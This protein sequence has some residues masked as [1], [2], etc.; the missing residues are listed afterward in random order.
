MNK[1]YSV[2]A[3]CAL[4][5]SCAT[6]PD[7]KIELKL[8]QGAGE[9]QSEEQSQIAQIALGEI[10]YYDFGEYQDLQGLYPN[11]FGYECFNLAVKNNTEKVLS[12]IWEKSSVIYS[13]S[14]YAPFLPGQKFIDHGKPA[15]PSI[16]PSGAEIRFQI[17]S[18][19]QVEYFERLK[20]WKTNRIYDPNVIIVLC[21]KSGDT[22]DIYTVKITKGQEIIR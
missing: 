15:S 11:Q 13:G 10:V 3:L 19:G 14:T 9:I 12:V 4:L 21:L 20:E 2:L 5:L 16:I 17:Y 22:E 7:K 1:R 18:A 6:T 8:F